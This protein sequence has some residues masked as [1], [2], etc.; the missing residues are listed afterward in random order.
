MRGSTGQTASKSKDLDRV[1][2]EDCVVYCLIE[3]TVSL[4][5]FPELPTLCRASSLKSALE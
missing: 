4:R 5:D 2:E 3:V 1:P